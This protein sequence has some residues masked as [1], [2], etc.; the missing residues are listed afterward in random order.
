MRSLT[1]IASLAAFIG[2]V[3][4]PAQETIPDLKGDWVATT[5]AVV[6]GTSPHHPGN[7]TPG[8]APRL[9]DVSFTFRVEAQEGRRVWGTLSS[10]TASERFAWAISHDNRT[11]LGSDSDG[12]FVNRLLEPNKLEICYTQTDNFGK[13]GNAISAVC[14][15]FERKAN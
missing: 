1:L 2:V 10:P 7:E 3:P 13:T 8:G 14:H 6:F 15:L 12:T 4:A 11:I 5:Q 9:R